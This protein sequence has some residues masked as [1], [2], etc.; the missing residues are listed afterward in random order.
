MRND[1]VAR[2][3][4]S[5]A[6]NF[7]GLFTNGGWGNPHGI[8]IGPH[9]GNIY[10]DDGMTGQIH[11]FDPSSFLEL[12]PMYLV[13]APGDKIV[14]MAFLPDPNPTSSIQTTWGRLKTLYK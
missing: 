10:V 3:S 9:D 8:V 11:V 14:D 12:N 7:L 2:F 1:Y 5:P 4:P 13:P 6:Y